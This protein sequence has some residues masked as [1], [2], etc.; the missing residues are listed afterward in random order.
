LS[1][2]TAGVTV[3]ATAGNARASVRVDCP[4]VQS[5]SI[6]AATAI[7]AEIYETDGTY[8]TP[9][10]YPNTSQL[11]VTITDSSAVSATASYSVGTV[12]LTTINLTQETPGGNVYVATLGPFGFSTMS[13]SDGS[14]LMHIRIDAQDAAGNAS[15]IN[16]DTVLRVYDCTVIF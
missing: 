7:P 4:D 2:S 12:P 10:D 16:A 8:C 6:G 11:R 1:S 15:F 14:L 3:V 13:S 9:P 5:P